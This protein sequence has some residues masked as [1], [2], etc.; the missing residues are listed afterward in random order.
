MKVL[1][2]TMVCIM[3][4]FS[5]KAQE[6]GANIKEAAM[7]PKDVVIQEDTSKKHWSFGGF[8]QLN[9]SQVALVNW[10]AGG[11]NSIAVQANANGYAHYLKGRL[12]WDN[13]LN[14]QWGFIAQGR[15]RDP[16]IKSK[17]PIRKN[18]DL[19]WLTSK[20]GVVL[21]KK[22]QLTAA[23][24][25]DYKTN[26]TNG[27]SYSNF[28]AGTGPRQIIATPFSPSFLTLSLGINYKP[29]PY[30]SVYLSPVA[31]KLTFVKNDGPKDTFSTH[32]DET[33][34]GLEA[35]KSMRAEFG[36]YLRADFQKD[37]F[38]NVNLKTSIELFQNYLEKNK[39]DALVQA[40]FDAGKISQ[41]DYDRRKTYDNRKNTDIN[42]NVALSFKVNKYFSAS[43]ETQLI[44]DHDT[45]VPKYR[46]DNTSYMGR[47]AQFRE[48][49]S[50]SLG[51]KF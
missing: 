16:N 36:A 51:Y 27:Y 42:W 30:F 28:D 39:K 32:V 9:V 50:L 14:I 44:Y 19:F 13:D 1:Y 37:I 10:A 15:L 43:L 12:A 47:G 48:A 35:G 21:D 4:V 34:Y 29:V 41:A 8:V 31:G 33:R 23:F 22:K 49:L 25:A 46:N 38:K 40:D 5:L 20:V 2:S 18:V 24:L 11:Q 6:T 17:Y 26:M 7:K 3:A 45:A